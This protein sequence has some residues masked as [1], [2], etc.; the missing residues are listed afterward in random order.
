V[1]VLDLRS[2][3]WHGRI[4]LIEKLRLKGAFQLH[5]KVS[6]THM[7]NHKSYLSGKQH[8]C[9]KSKQNVAIRCKSNFKCKTII[10]NIIFDHV[11]F[12][13]FS[14]YCILAAIQKHLHNQRGKY[15]SH[16][17]SD[18]SVLLP[19]NMMMTSLPRSVRTSSIHLDVWWKELASAH[20]QQ[21][22]NYYNHV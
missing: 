14:S 21:H 5:S 4:C 17:L 2:V 10:L 20:T 7:D 15:Q 9:L 16:L 3:P 11:F 13:Y 12:F 19:T 22:R 1:H 6:S 8:M 18:K